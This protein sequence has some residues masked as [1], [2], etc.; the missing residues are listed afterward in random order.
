MSL[1]FPTTTLKKPS[2]LTAIPSGFKRPSFGTLYGFD[3]PTIPTLVILTEASAFMQTEDG[4][5]LEFEF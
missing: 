1:T 3:A 5:F 4:F 2:G